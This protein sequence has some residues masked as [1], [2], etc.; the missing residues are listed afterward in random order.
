MP[1]CWV[2]RAVS[3]GFLLALLA[4]STMAAPVGA[5]QTGDR[6]T[7][8]L[9]APRTAGEISLD[10]ALRERRVLHKVNA[11]PLALADVGQ[12]LWAGQGVVGAR[13]ARTV[14]SA[15]GLYPLQLILV[16]GAVAGLPAGVYRYV[17]STHAL[18][19]TATGDRRNE[20]ATLCQLGAL[21]TAPAMVLVTGNSA[22]EAEKLGN[23]A[24]RVVAFEAGGAAQD[25]TVE[26][27]ALDLESGLAIGFT[28]PNLAAVLGIGPDDEVLA[29][30]TLAHP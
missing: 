25:M 20:I 21:G 29:V 3:T 17:P 11:T 24:A 9:P 23:R 12:I 27:T 19:R 8:P 5:Q 16:T 4:P 14:P 2:F 7:V 28:N 6:A 10:Q 15:G 26:A 22:R 30:L 1:I 13:G 18:E